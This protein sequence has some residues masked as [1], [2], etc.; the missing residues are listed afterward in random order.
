MLS[1][2]T[3]FF[4][5]YPGLIALGGVLIGQGLGVVLGIV[6]SSVCA[7]GALYVLH[8]LVS[9]EFDQR[10]AHNTVWIFA[11]L[12]IALVLSAVYSEALFLVLAIG[13]FYAARTGRWALA[14]VAGPSL[15]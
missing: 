12:P 1:S 2:Q 5:L 8:R 14:G 9:L 10:L 3:V 7:V 15:R 11:W 6:I 4:P 13:S